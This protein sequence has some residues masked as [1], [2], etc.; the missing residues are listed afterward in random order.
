MGLPA[1]LHL[2]FE[3]RP[4]PLDREF[5]NK[6][7]GEFNAAFLADQAFASFGIFARDG[8]GAIGGGLIGNT[9]AG[10]L[11]VNLLWVRDDLRRSGVGRAMMAEAERRAISLRCH[12]IWLD[13][14]SFQA[15]G[16]YRK[17]GYRE[18][19]RLDYPPGHQRIFFQKQLSAE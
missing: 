12:S 3:E 7:L 11:F 17:L 2:S 6:A 9:Y 5:V 1:G 18:F 15:P 14:F 16:F 8:G 4:S 19:G 13:T 10:W